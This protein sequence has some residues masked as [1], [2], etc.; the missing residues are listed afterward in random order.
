LCAFY[1]ADG[2][3]FDFVPWQCAWL[4]QVLWESLNFAVLAAVCVVC[5][6]TRKCSLGVMTRNITDEYLRSCE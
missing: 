3:G 1:N 6:P 5:R 2:M 4:E